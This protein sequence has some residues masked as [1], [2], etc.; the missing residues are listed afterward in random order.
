MRLKSWAIAYSGVWW[1][2]VK[3]Y[4]IKYLSNCSLWLYDDDFWRHIRLKSWEIAQSG[5]M[6]MICGMCDEKVEQLLNLLVWWWF[7]QK[8]EIKNLRNCSL[9]LYGDDLWRNMRLKSW[10]IAYSG[11]MVMI[12]GEIWD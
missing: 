1:W 6:V 2:F 7:V 5:C 10:A 4:D 11:C 3:Q 9:W 8:Y 12:C